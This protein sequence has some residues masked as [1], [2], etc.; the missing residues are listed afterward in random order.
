MKIYFEKGWYELEKKENKY[1]RW[2]GPE[3]EFIVEN[4]ENSKETLILSFCNNDKKN[5]NF[6]IL[7][8]K[9]SRAEF[10]LFLSSNIEYKKSKNIKIPIENIEKIKI[11]S[12]YFIP[13]NSDTRKLGL[14]LYDMFVVKGEVCSR[15]FLSNIIN[16]KYDF[17]AE[18]SNYIEEKKLINYSN[19]LECVCLLV[20]GNELSCG[21]YDHFIRQIK[22]TI[23]TNSKEN[24]KSIDF[25]ILIKSKDQNKYETSYLEDFRSVDFI[26]LEIPDKY[27]FY[28]VGKE[29]KDGRDYKYGPFSGPNYIFFNSF[30]YLKNYNTTLFL[31]C[32]CFLSNNWIDK[33]KNYVAFSSGFW[34]SGAVYDGVNKIVL[35]S[36]LNSHINGGVCLYKTSDFCFQNFMKLCFDMM[37]IYV[38]SNSERMPYDFFIKYTID[39]HFDND[40]KNRSIWQFI[41]RQYTK[42]NFIINYSTKND[43]KE[44]V[45]KIFQK[46]DCAVIHK[47]PF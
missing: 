46:Y 21:L 16:Y 4:S 20:T 23:K 13:N 3:S 9:K 11:K 30:N 25:K 12:D 27:D 1:Y 10:E 38:K 18:T 26:K 34:I 40:L 37:P 32:D 2:S 24:L 28:Q 6:S 5:N 41:R 22:N 45:E 33:L 15:I 43:I 42:N 7:I 14:M 35:D 8:K 19:N 31:E 29:E 44:S 39:Y 36:L 17:L 47:K